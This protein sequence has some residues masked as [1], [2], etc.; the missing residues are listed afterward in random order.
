M[1]AKTRHLS[2]LS[3]ML[4]MSMLLA[5]RAHA[6]PAV[7]A[8]APPGAGQ[9]GLAVGFD[10]AGS[11]R[12]APCAAPGCSIERGTE[13]AFPA[14]LRPAIPN[15]QFSVV[16]IGAGRR[17]IVVAVSD[18]HSGRNWHAVIVAPLG[19]GEPN[20]IFSGMTGLVE[21]EDGTRRGKASR[22]PR[23]MRAARTASS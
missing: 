8:F 21:G 22:F 19:A 6:A 3:A 4:M 1:I 10:A 17:A 9:G 11:L 18:A 2:A 20:L 15:A 7:V 12:A 23:R 5:A 14:E 13:L 16:G